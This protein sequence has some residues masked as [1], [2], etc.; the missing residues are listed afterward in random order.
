MSNSELKLLA[1]LDSLRKE[2]DLYQQRAEVFEAE[3]E[4]LHAYIRDLKRAVFGRKSEK[5]I[6]PAQICLPFDE[7][8]KIETPVSESES[9][10]SIESYKR[11]KKS[12]AKHSLPRQ[13][14]TIPVEEAQRICHCGKCKSV[15]RYET[16]EIINYVAPVYELIEERREVVACPSRCEQSIVVAEKPRR[17]LPKI[18]VS[19]SFLAYIITSKINDRQPLYHLEKKLSSQYGISISR[20]SMAKWFID[21]YRP[22]LPIFNLMKD[23]I[24]EHDVASL[25]ATTLQVLNEPDRPPTRKSYVYC[26]R[27]G[28]KGN[29]AIL[30]D[31]N[32]KN[33]KTYVKN[34]FEGFSGS[35]HADA[36]PFFNLLADSPGNSM[37]YC[38]AHTRR[39][40]EKITKET[41]KEGLA[42]EAMRF[43]Q[44]LYR[45]E[46]KAKSESLTSQERFDLRQ[47]YSNPI[48]IKFKLWLD[49]H[50]E[51]VGPKF[52]IGKAIKY[53]LKYWDGLTHY[54]NDGRIE[55]DNNHTE[56]EIKPFV[57]ARK[58]FMFCHSQA[59]ARALCLHFSLIRTAK[60]HGLDPYRYYVELL[61]SVPH[62]E[63][64][65]DYEAL[66]P[67]SI[68]LNKSSL[69]HAA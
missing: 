61:R 62:C 6:S 48:M 50:Y 57:I 21:L 68:Q 26:F 22:L 5:F 51:V 45:I 60:M 55:I 9:V 19:E 42:H 65:S 30:Y 17:V 69:A 11:S 46:R 29:E 39:R 20:Q 49:E 25:D 27:G 13:I 10:I 8:E 59:G 1:K 54:L 66:L 40:F 53:C 33:H 36:D 44:K 67:W 56:R 32:E 47:Q 64:V 23:H 31:Y 18:G 3:A 24:I 28:G 16:Q 35:V 37:A 43:Y 58:N 4:R 2:R 34:W 15:I 7:A 14:V 38:N 41:E 63:A 52:P 12:K